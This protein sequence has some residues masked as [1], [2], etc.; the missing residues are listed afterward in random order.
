MKIILYACVALVL[1]AC[2][3]RPP[4][5]IN[6]EL[7]ENPSLRRVRMDVDAFIGTEVRWGGVISR[8][9]NRSEETWVEIVRHGLRDS[10]RPRVGTQSD[11]RFIASF[12]DFTD[13]VVYEVGRPLTVLGRIV[14]HSSRKIGD[15]DYRL[16]IVEV[17]GSFL[18]ESAAEP[19]YPNYPP[20][21]WY[22]DPWYRPWGPY[23]RYPH[24]H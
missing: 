12:G 11:G 19:Q 4:D 14:S 6:R 3:A 17:D 7:A 23:H 13:P 22:H 15:Y 20:Y 8:V 10:G 2:A 5:S 9:E 16:V 24:F 1:G 21:W 18:W